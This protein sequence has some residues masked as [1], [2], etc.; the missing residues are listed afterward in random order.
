MKLFELKKK[1]TYIWGEK[2]LYITDFIN[3]QM[4][5][6]NESAGDI[7]IQKHTRITFFFIILTT[8]MNMCTH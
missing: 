4:S 6:I 2:V 7:V 1:K 8:R 3:A 5:K